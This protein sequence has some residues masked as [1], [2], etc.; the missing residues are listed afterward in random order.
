[1]SLYQELKDKYKNELYFCVCEVC[2]SYSM[3]TIYRP[4]ILENGEY[5]IRQLDYGF[6][7]FSTQNIAKFKTYRDASKTVKDLMD[8]NKLPYMKITRVPE[9]VYGESSYTTICIE[10]RSL[11]DIIGHGF[12]S[13]LAG[14]GEVMPPYKVGDIVYCFGEAPCSL[15]RS[16]I[17]DIEFENGKFKYAT[18]YYAYPVTDSH[19]ISKKVLDDEYKVLRTDERGNPL[20]VEK[21]DDRRYY[22]IRN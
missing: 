3:G 21:K 12:E 14:G 16:E 19:F 22:K 1:M 4:L 17:S 18:D 10:Q 20:S 2:F 15:V 5:K 7:P 13:Y 6:F 9:T 11:G 8:K